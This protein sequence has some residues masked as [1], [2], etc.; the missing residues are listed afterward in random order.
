[1]EH[2]YKSRALISFE[3][4]CPM[5]CKH[6]YTY[7]LDLQMDDLDINT[8]VK[9]LT[10]E[11]CDIIYVSQRYENFWDEDRGYLLCSE[12]YSKYHKDI[13]IITRSYLSDD[14]I[15]KLCCLNDLMCRE[16]NTL[17]LAVSVC[18]DESYGITEN[19][20]LC[21]TPI[22]RLSNLQRAHIC[23]IKTV[24][25]LRPIFP[26]EIIPVTECTSLISQFSKCIDAVVT[27]GLIA[28]ERI[29]KRLQISKKDLSYLPSGDSTYLADLKADD[30][31]YLDV[32]DELQEIERQ[33][34]IENIPCF[35]HS[36]PA[37]NTIT[38]K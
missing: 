5:N 11:S 14:M 24:L 10:S 12:L 19:P 30:V 29:L 15:Q 16:D 23:G 7:D 25:M 36:M 33:C 26:N 31:L 37:L 27:S 2:K 13:F 17:F 35:R 4:K 20:E 34:S 6:C 38:N 3:G 8:T 18:A 28:T 32:E 21:P 9:K 1:M 22:Q